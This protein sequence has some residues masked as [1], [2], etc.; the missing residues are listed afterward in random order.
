MASFRIDVLNFHS[1]SNELTSWIHNYL[2]GR[3][4][5]VLGGKRIDDSPGPELSTLG[6]SPLNIIDV[7]RIGRFLNMPVSVRDRFYVGGELKVGIVGFLRNEDF[8][9]SSR[10]IF[11]LERTLS[12]VGRLCVEVLL[13]WIRGK[14][15]M[16]D[17]YMVLSLWI[18]G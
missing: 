3:W 6:L 14:L 11:L 18:N 16:V 4:E 8:R 2:R 10:D 12:V 7:E 13:A 5:Q 17:R 1:V 9:G 15:L